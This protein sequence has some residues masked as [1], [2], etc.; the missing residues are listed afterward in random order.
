M[1]T[2]EEI[3]AR[4]EHLRSHPEVKKL[5]KLLGVTIDRFLEDI[6]EQAENCILYDAQ[7][8]AERARTENEVLAAAE[9]AFQEERE[10][11]DQ[12]ACR[13]DGFVGEPQRDRQDRMLM[14]VGVD[15]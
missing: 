7:T 1:L 2:R 15:N 4:K 12:K 8:D 10:A 13:K 11:M 3:Q 14:L 9:E 6:E 5:C